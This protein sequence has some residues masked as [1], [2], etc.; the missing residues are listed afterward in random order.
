MAVTV[1]IKIT[2]SFEANTSLSKAFE[3]LADVEGT[4]EN[5]PKLDSIIELDPDVYRWEMEKIGV[6][7]LSHQV[8]YAVKYSNNGKDAI[9][10]SPVADAQ[11][12]ARVSGNW[13]LKSKTDQLVQIDF[14]S[15]GEF[16]LPVPGL[17]K[18]LAQ[19]IVKTEFDSQ[20]ETFLSRLKTKLS[21]L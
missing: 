9:E 12:N 15:E 18:G 17:M 3:S 10:W 2:K 13:K 19:G 6:S 8:K 20:V 14:E 16:D 5:F 11:S 1:T 7:G 21:A 4:V